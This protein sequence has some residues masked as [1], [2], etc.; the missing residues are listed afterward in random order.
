MACVC[1]FLFCCSSDGS[2]YNCSI[3]HESILCFFFCLFVNEK[4]NTFEH[5][6]SIVRVCVLV[7]FFSLFAF[8][9]PNCITYVLAT[10]NM[11]H[12]VPKQTCC[13]NSENS[14]NTTHIFSQLLKSDWFDAT[15]I[16]VW[17][18]VG[19]VLP[20]LN[21]FQA[22]CSVRYWRRTDELGIHH[23]GSCSL[24][25]TTFPFTL[26]PTPAPAPLACIRFL[27]AIATGA[28]H[29]FGYLVRTINFVFSKQKKKRP[30]TSNERVW[31]YFCTS[32]NK[33]QLIEKHTR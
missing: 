30:N 2:V 24:N 14:A 19:W 31:K 12:V 11:L 23:L 13:S 1:L 22:V 29:T 7:L 16:Y 26:S 27:L 32:L 17:C 3:I 25:M 6:R 8:Y 9:L 33:V 4:I 18:I 28:I 5:A 10:A 15:A 21:S 20:P